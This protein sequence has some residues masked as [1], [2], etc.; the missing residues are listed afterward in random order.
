MLFAWRQIEHRREGK[1]TELQSMA[2]VIAFNASAVVE[3]QDTP[4]AER[5]FS[6]LAS[7]P[8]IVAARLLGSESGFSFR[9][10]RPG[11]HLPLQVREG[12][13]CTGACCGWADFA[14]AT[15]IVPIQLHDAVIGS[16]ALTA[17]L[18]SVWREVIRDSALFLLAALIAFVV[19]LLIARKL[20]QG[21][22]AALAALTATAHK[23]A[24]SKDF[25]QRATRFC[26]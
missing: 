4:G 9:Y 14:H 25:S 23:V 2:E 8:D 16:V 11:A 21:I 1:L 24:E 5:L 18:D 10:D 13:R 26:R 22:L 15:V 7:H 6:A 17:S 20:Q 3:F 12:E 19:A